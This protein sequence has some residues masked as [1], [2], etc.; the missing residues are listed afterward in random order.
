M[1]WSEVEK[2]LEKDDVLLKKQMEYWDAADPSLVGPRTSREMYIAFRKIMRKTPKRVLD[3]GCGTGRLLN[4]FDPNS[5]QYVGLDISKNKLA[6]AH[7]KND[8]ALLI[9]N[10]TNPQIPFLDEYFDAIICYSVFTHTPKT[11][12]TSI[13][14]EFARV[15]KR[16]G[17]IY[18]SII[19]DCFAK[20]GNWILTNREWF[21]ENTDN[22]GLKIVDESHVSEVENV[23]QTLFVLEKEGN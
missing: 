1:S 14:S 15:L 7:E 3:F 20:R 5:T 22:L 21:K 23:Y 18:A 16:E 2:S 17:L 4:L 10:G 6:L 11:Q 9:W 19:E 12:T 8:E 13:L